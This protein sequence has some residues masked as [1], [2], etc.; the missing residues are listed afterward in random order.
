MT[1][2]PSTRTFAS[3]ELA[4]RRAIG[5]G[6][7]RA[8]LEREQLARAR[9]PRCA[10]RRRRRRRSSSRFVRSRRTLA[11]ASRCSAV[12]RSVERRCTV[13]PTSAADA[14]NTTSA[15]TSSVRWILNEP[16]GSVKN[17]FSDKKPTIAAASPAGKPS[18]PTARTVTSRSERGGGEV[19]V[20]RRGDAGDRAD[21]DDRQ[22]DPDHGSFARSASDRHDRTDPSH[23][24]HRSG[25]RWAARPVRG[26][27]LASADADVRNALDPR[28]GRLGDR[29]ARS[30]SASGRS[31]AEV[32][33]LG[34]KVHA[35][36]ALMGQYDFLNI[37]E[38]PDEETM[39]KA[40]IMLAARGTMRTTTLPAIPVE[41]L[42][43]RLKADALSRQIHQV[44]RRFSSR[45]SA[46]ANVHRAGSNR[47]SGGGPCTSARRA[48][49]V[50]VDEVGDFES[51]RPLRLEAAPDLDTRAGS[52]ASSYGACPAVLT[53]AQRDPSR[54]IRRVASRVVTAPYPTL[55]VERK[56]WAA[57]D[58]DRGRDRRGRPRLVGRSG[59]G[60]RG[61]ARRRAPCAACAT[62]SC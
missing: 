21:G 47:P 50:A 22:R 5:A 41:Q 2:G 55:R 27:P 29:C 3:R 43:A 38:A 54:A 62:R 16:V 53:C 52:H 44:L 8:R 9:R 25:G 37:I 51:A 35:Q 36:Y 10:A 26:R 4:G 15:T 13:Q 17:Q 7:E 31:T 28:S 39:A 34:L 1:P 48:G 18:V 58:R 33:A 20:A 12:R 49:R 61:R 11:S 32:E 42:I 23:A 6:G 30:P 59:D 40:A 60:R 24:R 57:G 14:A 56:C 45:R 19:G 46:S